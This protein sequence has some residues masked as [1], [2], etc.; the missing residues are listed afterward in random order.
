[1]KTHRTVATTFVLLALAPLVAAADP[2]GTISGEIAGKPKQR[3]NVVVHLDKVTGSFRP[4]A[5]P[6]TID[7]KGMQFVPHVLAVQK[8]GTVV[9]RN[10]DAVRHNVFT[11]DGD[12]YNL[13]TWGQGETKSHTFAASGVFTQLCNVHPEMR[14]VIVVLDHPFFAVTD[15]SGK[16]EIP[17]VPPG[18]YTLKAWSEKGPEQSRPVTVTA[19]GTATVHFEVGR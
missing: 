8:G 19:G 5:R 16:F 10:S 2:T 11:P 12:K 1:M 15:E 3:A 14:A 6:S 4:P 18:S 9:F 7:Q 17:N 13:G